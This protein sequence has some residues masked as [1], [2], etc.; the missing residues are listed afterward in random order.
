MKTILLSIILFIPLIYV[1]PKITNRTEITATI[2]QG[3][4]LQVDDRAYRI[5][6]YLQ[7]YSSPLA[8]NSS[9]FVKTADKYHLDWKVL[10]AISGAE[11]T[12]GKA[13]PPQS[14]NPFGMACWP[15][16][17][18]ARFN[19]FADAIDYLGQ[20]LATSKYY[21]HYRTTKEIQDLAENYNPSGAISWTHS[22]KYFMEEIN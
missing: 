12:F 16:H 14:F 11:S 1:I 22:V 19:S 17:P 4:G 8:D 13:I 10:V 15:G 2:K 7:G 6:I 5:R 9:D 21:A 18:C 3:S 20:Q